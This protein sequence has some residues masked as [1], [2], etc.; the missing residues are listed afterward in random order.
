MI[1]YISSKYNA[2][3]WGR[4]ENFWLQTLDVWQECIIFANKT[5][6]TYCIRRIK[7]R[8]LPIPFY[9]PGKRCLYPQIYPMQKYEMFALQL[10]PFDANIVWHKGSPRIF[11]I[12]RKRYVSLTPE[13]WVRQHFV[14]FLITSRGYPRALMANEVSIIAGIT[15][16]RC[17]TVV[18]AADGRPLAVV[19][20]KAPGV[21][22]NEKVLAQ[23]WSYNC[24]LKVPCV[25]I[26]NG[27][28]HHCFRLVYEEAMACPLDNIPYYADLVS[29]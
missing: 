12:L 16:R 15:S 2:K 11:D 25:M 20:Y 22:L 26:S 4:D 13:E 21:P 9:L 28:S 5:G 18:H 3:A 6:Q 8:N 19:E 24:A 29:L 23:V 17:D 7:Q 1:L 14:H 10:P 27:M